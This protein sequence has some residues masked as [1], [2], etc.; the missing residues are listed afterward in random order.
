MMLAGRPLATTRFAAFAVTH[1]AVPPRAIDT[2]SRGLRARSAT[3]AATGTAPNV[4][5]C[6][7]V[8]IGGNAPLGRSLAE[9]K[10][11]ISVSDR[12]RRASTAAPARTPTPSAT[13]AI[14]REDD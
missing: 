13:P 6:I 5:Y 2:A 14:S 7:A 3:V 9:R 4:P 12:A 8:Q 1:A 10:T 11:P